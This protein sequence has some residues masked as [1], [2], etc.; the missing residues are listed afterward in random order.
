VGAVGLCSYLLIGFYFKK[1]EAAAAA[2]K[3]FI[4][5]RIGDFGFALGIFSIYYFLKDHP[6]G[7]A[8]TRSI[9]PRLKYAGV[10]ASSGNRAFSDQRRPLD[11]TAAVVR[12][13]RQECPVPAVRLVA[14]RDGRS[15]A[16]LGPDSRRDDGDRRHLHDRPLRRRCSLASVASWNVMWVGVI[17]AVLTA[18]MAMAQYDMK[19]ILAYSTISQ[20]AFMFVALGC[21]APDVGRVPRVHARMVQGAAVPRT[22]GIV[23]HAMGGIIDVRR[24]SGLQQ[25]L[26]TKRMR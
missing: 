17:G 21:Q 19:R 13:A 25:V 26:P 8:R 7:R 6:C 12:R 9:T 15:D 20:L 4:V 10:I 14:R 1:P 18:T 5:N 16:G 24:F 3:A 22:A 2:K 23:M 11:F